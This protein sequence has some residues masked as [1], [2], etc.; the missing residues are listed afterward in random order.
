MMK[1]D[2]WVLVAN[3]SCAKIF[4]ALNN[5]DLQEVHAFEHL[6]SRLHNQDLVSEKPGRN[7]TSM[8]IRKS[9]LDYQTS[10]KHQEF[11]LFAKQI[12]DYLDSAREEGKFGRLYV[13][14]GPAFLGI[15]RQTFSHLTN[16]M[17]ASEVD[18]DITH[19]PTSEIRNHLP[20]T[21]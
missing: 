14:A 12:S 17:I 9:A 2:T 20:L 3:S 19:L 5:H 15:L 8:G 16:A 13:T 6:E 1:K 11:T 7:N 18:H 4:K 10:P 21:L